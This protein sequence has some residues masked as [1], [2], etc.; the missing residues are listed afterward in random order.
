M[1]KVINLQEKRLWQECWSEL[2]KDQRSIYL[3]AEYYEI[4][5]KLGYGEASCVIFKRNECLF[6]YPFLKRNLKKTGLA[7]DQNE[8]FDVEGA[9]GLNGAG[10]KF[11]S[12]ADLNEI[13]QSWKNYCKLNH[14]IAEFARFNPILSNNEYSPYLENVSIGEVVIVDLTCQ[15]LMYDSYEHSVRKNIK[16]AIKQNVV[17]AS[18]ASKDLSVQSFNNF[19]DIYYNTMDRNK[20]S[21]FYYFKPEFFELVREHLPDNS[22]WFFAFNEALPVSVEL[23]LYD[24]T[25]CYSFL[26]GTLPEHFNSGANVLLKNEIILFFQ[27]VG[28]RFFFLGGGLIANDGIFK[29]KK[30]FAKNSSERFF[31]GKKV[32][33]EKQYESFVQEW[34]KRNPDKIE[35]YKNFLLKYWH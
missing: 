22:R 23:V 5:E 15:D 30:N 35:V 10:S 13:E 12:S 7:I 28:L 16:K 2:P 34:G 32:H 6:L 20:A 11:L 18:F 19:I 9:Y 8:Y 1:F 31:I 26:G 27:A 25:T 24:E 33:L 4:Y 21:S 14:I 17:V 3:K 29:Y